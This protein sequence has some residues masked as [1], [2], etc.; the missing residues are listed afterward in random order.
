[1]VDLSRRRLLSAGMPAMGAATLMPSI[2][3]AASIG[4]DRRSGSIRDVQHV[5]ILTQENRAFDHYFGSMNGVQGFGDRFAIPAPPLPEAP[6]RTVFVQPAEQDKP[7]PRLLAPFRLDTQQDFRLI[8]PLG[9]PHSFPDS[10]AAWDNGRMADW[11]RYKHNHAL[12]HFTRADIPFQYALAEAFTL[13]DAYHCALHLSTNPNRLYIW[14]GTHDPQ[15]KANGPAIDNGYDGF[16]DPRGHGGYTWTTYPERLL[17]AGVSFQ[18][19][20]DMS[21]NFSDN[22]LVGFKAYRAA[23]GAME[24]PA[25]ELARRTLTSRTL[26]DLRQDVLSG[27]LPQVSWIVAPAVYS[28]HPSV[29]TPLQGAE[30]TARVLDALTAN[31]DVWSR[32]VLLINFDENDGLFDHV[33]PPAPPARDPADP[34]RLLGGSTVEAG[35]EYHRHSQG[36]K[37]APY[38]NRPYGLGPRVPMYVVSPWS[39]GGYVAPEVFDHTSVIR[40][41]EARFGVMEPN[42][43]AW[44]RAVC[45]D[46]TSCFDFARRDSRPFPA[47]LPPTR[48]LSDRAAG[49]KEVDPPLPAALTAPSQETGPR[50]RRATPYRLDVALGTGLRFL[51]EGQARAAVFHLYR[52]GQL[53]QAPARYTVG[54]GAALEAVLEP[55]R[56]LFIVGPNGFHRRLTGWNGVFGAAFEQGR[57]RQALLRL[58]NPGTAGLTLTLADLA[59]GQGTRQVKVPAGGETSLPLDFAGSHG[60][61]DLLLSAAGQS[62]RMAGHLEDGSESFSDPATLAA[63]PLRVVGLR[64]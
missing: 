39:T 55:G 31:P 30:Y 36:E 53:D 35:D 42:I 29:S 8:R 15:A 27:T 61:Y 17:A 12:A 1:M 2:V 22:P 37:D 21:D 7:G 5:V 57:G 16:E 3:R 41:L 20:Q 24:G 14:T 23:R 56:D 64:G 40:F 47:K 59:Y 43:S 38:L 58:S 13:C 9:T 25:A 11:P 28:E 45:G 19:Y 63:A 49:L 33:P 34:D 54:A 52:L 44:R 50:R 48:A 46:L 60:W 62:W 18:I 6:D 10:Q 4:P 51:N 26:D 32:T